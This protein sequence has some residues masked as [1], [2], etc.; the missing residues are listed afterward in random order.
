MRGK[1]GLYSTDIKTGLHIFLPF[2]LKHITL[3]T[4]LFFSNVWWKHSY[5][6]NRWQ[7]HDETWQLNFGFSNGAEEQSDKRWANVMQNLTPH[8]KSK[9]AASYSWWLLCWNSG[10]KTPDLLVSNEKSE[11]WILIWNFSTFGCW[12]KTIKQIKHQLNI[13]LAKQNSFAAHV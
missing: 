8:L 6:E 4:W 12:P 5:G 3:K 9:A 2:F 10:P 13:M 11:I 7:G 1:T